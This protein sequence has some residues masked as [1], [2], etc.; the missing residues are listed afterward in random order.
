[1]KPNITNQLIDATF[2]VSRLIKENMCYTS[3]I[4]QLSMLQL[5]ALIFIKRNPNVPMREIAEHFRIELPSATS[6]L[7]KLSTMDLVE[8]LTDPKD[9]RIV[10]VSLTTAGQTLLKNAMIEKTSKIE[11]LLAFLSK[12]EKEALLAII[13]TLTEKMEAQHA[14]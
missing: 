9:R 11:K 3:S 14:V 10:R 6:L 5:Q 2:K 13:M 1:M 4:T 12:K 7:N 8:R